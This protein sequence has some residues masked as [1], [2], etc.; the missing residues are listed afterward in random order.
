MT[1]IPLHRAFKDFG[2]IEGE[3]ALPEREYQTL[4][5]CPLPW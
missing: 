2:A 1:E 5:L 4:P 3:R